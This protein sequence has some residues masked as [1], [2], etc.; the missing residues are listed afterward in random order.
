[1]PFHMTDREEALTELPSATDGR[2]I[3]KVADELTVD[4]TT[5]N[6]TPIE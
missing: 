2:K 4:A 6:N 3:L 1:M 5:N